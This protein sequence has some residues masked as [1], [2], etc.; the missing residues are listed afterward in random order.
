MEIVY[1]KT[2]SMKCE[3]CPLLV[4][5]GDAA[6]G[7]RQ[8]HWGQVR[9]ADGGCKTCCRRRFKLG[10]IQPYFQE[11]RR[12]ITYQRQNFREYTAHTFTYREEDVDN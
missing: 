9:L 8:P 12:G 6:S 2:V 3:H 11:A 1:S 10:Q 4:E 7:H 5:H